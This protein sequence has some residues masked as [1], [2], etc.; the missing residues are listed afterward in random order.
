[1]ATPNEIA[2]LKTNWFNDPIW[3]IEDTEGFEAHYDE[4]KTYH[5]TQRRLWKEARDS[6]MALKALELGCSPELAAYIQRLEQRI[7]HLESV[8]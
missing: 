2:T 1:M 6:E 8:S 3:D 4:L 7:A 5:E